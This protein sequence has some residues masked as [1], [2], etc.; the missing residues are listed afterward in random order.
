MDRLTWIISFAL[1]T[2]LGLTLVL[3]CGLA[4][5]SGLRGWRNLLMVALAQVATNPVV[6]SVSLWMRLNT[7]VFQFVYEFP[8]E[9]AAVVAEWLMY[10]RLLKSIEQPFCFSLGLNTFSYSCGYIWLALYSIF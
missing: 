8:L 4:R 5:F 2:S 6:V 9:I 10:K 1:L 3:E 7:D